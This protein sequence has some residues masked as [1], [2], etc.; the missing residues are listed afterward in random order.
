MLGYIDYLF[1]RAIGILKPS[2]KRQAWENEV[3][4]RY[5]TKVGMKKRRDNSGHAVLSYEHDGK[6]DYE[7]YRE[8][9]TL[10]NKGKIDRVSVQQSN[11]EY[12]CRELE[13][14]VS[15]IDFVLCHGTRNAA[16]Q[17]FFAAA[18]PQAKTI[19]GTEI[20]DTADQFPMT[21]Q[22][23]FHE[24]KPEWRGAV[25]VVFSNSFDHSY[26]PDKLFTAWLSC[27]RVNGIM[28]LEWCKAHN[29]TGPQILDPY[30]VSLPGLIEL[31]RKYCADGAFRLLDPLE[32]APGKTNGETYLLVQ[33]VR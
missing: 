20:S 32:Q 25:D 8:I 23:D 19:L 5:A 2:K 9:Q 13:K 10:G 18:L 22:W 31:L 12:L 11:I 15:P 3:R 33:R 4:R 29:V 26:D 1:Y 14:H 28:A 17:K 6:F 24:V 16:E 7:L 30:K 27:L 21:I